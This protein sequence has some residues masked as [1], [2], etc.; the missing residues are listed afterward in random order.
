MGAV[1]EIFDDPLNFF[2]KKRSFK[3]GVLLLVMSLL[4]FVAMNQVMIKLGFVQFYLSTDP[5]TAAVINFATLLGGYIV[6][7]A[8][9]LIPFRWIGGK[10]INHLFIV[11]AY[12]LIPISFFWI[13]HIIP[14]MI[15]IFLGFL[16]MTRG[17]A[18]YCK[19]NNKKALI[20]TV[21]FITIAIALSLTAQNFILL[22]N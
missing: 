1:K 11:S 12:S 15:A 21:F 20:V 13:P 16:L 17:V 4:I 7:T 19:T 8:I 10:K 9:S 5:M 18:I 3:T 6:V 2:K 22:V 14:Q